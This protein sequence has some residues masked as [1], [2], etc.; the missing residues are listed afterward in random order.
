MALSQKSYPPPPL[1]DP[2]AALPAVLNH[3]LKSEPA[4]RERLA[5]HAG[6]A[7]FVVIAPF[8]VRLAVAEEGQIVTADATR[9]PDLRI[10]LPLA[11]LPQWFAGTSSAAQSRVKI[12]G[13]VPFAE[14]VAEV[15]RHVRWDAEEDLSRIIGDVAARRVTQSSR[16]LWNEARA[17]HR[18][19]AENFAEFWLEED[20][21]LVRPRHVEE[22]ATDVRSLRDD[23]ERLGKRI[24]QLERVRAGKN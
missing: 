23:L 10:E 14:A 21:E 7:L 17:S 20:R 19:L 16:A 22:L 13:D 8:H 2:L 12:E 3:L 1:P 24:E 6:K 15:A 18:K 5:A 4:A 9:E 11:M